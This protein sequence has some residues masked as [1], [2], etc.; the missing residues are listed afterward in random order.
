MWAKNFAV[1]VSFF[2]YKCNHNR[3]KNVIFGKDMKMNST[4][5]DGPLGPNPATLDFRPTG[6]ANLASARWHQLAVAKQDLFGRSREAVCVPERL[7][8]QALNE[9]EALAWQTA[10]P[11]LVFPVL[12]GEKLQAVAEWSLTQQQVRRQS[13]TFALAA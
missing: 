2:E 10:Y 4:D 3:Y 1:T 8:Q 13:P 6:G 9:A 5:T 11:Q 12:A 7:L